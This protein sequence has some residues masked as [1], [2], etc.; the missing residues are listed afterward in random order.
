MSILNHYLVA[1]LHLGHKN[2][3]KHDNRPYDCIEQHDVDLARRCVSVGGKHATLWL[4]GDVAQTKAALDAFMGVIRPH[5]GK[6]ILI[7]GNHDDKVAWKYRDMFDEAHEARYLRVS[8]E[9]RVYI[10]HYAHRVWRNSHHGAYHIHGHSHGALPRL[11]RSIDCGAP[12]VNYTPKPLQWFVDELSAAGSTNHHPPKVTQ[13]VFDMQETL[14]RV[15][16]ISA[17]TN[18]FGLCGVI[19]IAQDGRVWEL[20]VSACSN[21]SPDPQLVV[22]ATYKAMVTDSHIYQGSLPFTFEIPK[23]LGIAPAGAVKAVWGSS[24]T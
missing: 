9:V 13:P 5:W 17:N 2:V 16:I 6:I 20:G 8:P 21:T 24:L 12:C 14:L 22:G 4:V 15:A 1:D 23:F 10:S 11:G 3:L 7:R 19:L 18:T